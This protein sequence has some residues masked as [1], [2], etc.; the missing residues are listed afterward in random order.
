MS[1]VRIFLDLYRQ[2]HR[3]QLLLD[4]LNQANTALSKRALQL[5]VNSQLSRQVTSILALPELLSS[6]VALLQTQFDYYFVSIWL[7][8]EPKDALS[9]R[10]GS[11]RGRI[12]GDGLPLGCVLP[13]ATEQSILAYVGRT[14]Q[15]YLANDTCAD[16]RYLPVAALPETCAELVI[17]L[18]LGEVAL[19][20]L[21]IESEQ[22]GAFDPED[23]AVLQSLADQIAIAIRNAQ[24][25]AKVVTFNEALESTVQERT[26]ALEQAYQQLEKIDRNKSDFIQVI[27][28]ELRTPLTLILGYGYMLSSDLAAAE[29]GRC[30]QQ[31]AGIIEGANRLADIVNAMLDMAYID[32]SAL[33][34]I[35]APVALGGLLMGLCK[36]L[37]PVLVERGLRLRLEGFAALPQAEASGELLEKVFTNLLHNAIKYTPDGGE[38]VVRGQ[39]V[40]TSAVTSFVEVVVS[41][42][43]IGI[44]PE[45]HELIFT[46][47]YQTGRVAWHSSGKTKF[48]GGGPGLGLAIARG[49]V[50]AHGGKI[51]VESPGHDEAT[52][53][54]SQFH[55]LLPL[56]AACAAPTDLMASMARLR[57]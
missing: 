57:S 32:N 42:T 17:P 41:D 20:V 18:H 50:E 37:E 3:L 10:A 40:E 47:F 46:K 54:G 21:D 1:K 23:I 35:L 15:V 11:Q 5:E 52:C 26:V 39:L 7:L 29:N 6:V 49:I 4:Q 34:I 48:K 9:L 27:S 43:G 53:P 24:L 22:R 44:A 51:W 33:E 13:L 36:T 8:N 19:G 31:V 2:R 28:H 55:V 56:K 14:G 25:Y 45:C 16:P 38:I 12:D 30:R